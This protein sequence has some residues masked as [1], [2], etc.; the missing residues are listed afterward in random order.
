MRNTLFTLASAGVAAAAS[1]DDVCTIDYVTGALP[2]SGNT[3]GITLDTASVTA[4]PVTNY[5]VSG[6]TFFPDA[7]FDYCNVTFA[8]S[9]NGKSDSVSLQ[10]WLP[11]PEAYESRFLPTGG[12]AYAIN[13]GFSTTN[14]AGGVMYGAVAGITDGGFGGF[15]NTFD[16]VFLAANGSINWDA[17]YMMGYQGI[18]EMTSIGKDFTSNFF[19]ETEKVYTYYQ[20]SSIR[21]KF[22]HFSLD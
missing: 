2:V 17:T 11:T 10:Y 6:Q 19:N 12:S 1:L 14:L 8:Y 21:L 15:S 9:H 4:N 13:A 5:T 18:G 20:V 3:A 22:F 7:T 16:E